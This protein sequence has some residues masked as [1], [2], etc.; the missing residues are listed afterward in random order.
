[1]L[2]SFLANVTNVYPTA[3]G[4]CYLLSGGSYQE[5]ITEPGA[6][7]RFDTATGEGN[8]AIYVPSYDVSSFVRR[9]DTVWIT[10]GPAD[11]LALGQAG[12]SSVAMLGSAITPDKVQRV[13]R[14]YPRC[15][16]YYVM[17]T[18]SAGW[19]GYHLATQYATRTVRP[20]MLP[21]GV[22]DFCSV[23]VFDRA[24]MVRRWL[25][26]GLNGGQQEDVSL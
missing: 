19:T 1:V 8:G 10:E 17:D 23:A 21:L 7:V 18:D 16:L 20:A 9:T 4:V 14:L 5:R 26:E 11:T 6:Y 12:L 15:T 2:R 3:K 22:K 25:S 24:A 13:E